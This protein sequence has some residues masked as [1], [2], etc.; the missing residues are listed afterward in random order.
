MSVNPGMEST[1]EAQIV[2]RAVDDLLKL[3]TEHD[4]LPGPLEA[5]LRQLRDQLTDKLCPYPIEQLEA[6]KKQLNE[7]FPR[8]DHWYI[9]CGS[10]VTW[11]DRRKPGA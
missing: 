7:R 10:T 9:R 11:C 2:F 5:G 8:Y 6:E 4:M 1:K 3:L